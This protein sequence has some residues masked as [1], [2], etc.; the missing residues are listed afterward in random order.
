MF[1]Q[2][3]TGRR[4][5]MLLRIQRLVIII[6]CLQNINCNRRSGYLDCSWQYWSLEKKL[7]WFFKAGELALGQSRILDFQ[8]N[9]FAWLDE[10]KHEQIFFDN[11][12]SFLILTFLY[13]D[14]FQE[15]MKKKFFRNCDHDF[16][17]APWNVFTAHQLIKIMEPYW[18]DKFSDC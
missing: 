17:P 12:R 11:S 10:S 15:I 5:S 2:M 16:Y 1:L 3:S 14:F 6:F 9:N 8:S 4:F 7:Y 13:A 18:Y